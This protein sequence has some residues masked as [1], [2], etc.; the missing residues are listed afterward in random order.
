MIDRDHAKKNIHANLVRLLAVR[1]WS[2]RDLVFA[3]GEPHNNVYR[4]V[5]GESVPSAVTLRNLADALDVNTDT[6][7]NPPPK[8][9]LQTVA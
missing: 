4:T 6:L 1:G 5:R 9:N 7:L 8:Q 3:S 2:I